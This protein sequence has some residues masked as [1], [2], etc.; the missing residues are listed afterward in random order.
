[1][2][3][4]TPG[5][6]RPLLF[7]AA[8][9]VGLV[10]LAAG[11]SQFQL[12]PGQPFPYQLIFSDSTPEAPQISTPSRLPATWLEFFTNLGLF[13]LTLVLLLWVITFIFKPNARKRMLQR[14]AYYLIL[15]LVLHTVLGLVRELQPL[16]DLGEGGVGAES[17]EPFEADVPL[18]EPPAFIVDPPQWLVVALTFGLV[19]LLFMALWYLFRQAK[20]AGS[21]PTE[22]TPIALLVQEA[23]QAL[24]HLQQGGDF[25][26]SVL[27]CYQAMT[28][29]LE[30]DRG[31]H[32]E[33][34]MT[35]RDFEAHLLGLG[36]KDAHIQRLTRLFEKVR[37]GASTPS[38]A[39]EEEAVD[40][41]SAIVQ[42]YGRAA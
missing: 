39:E 34:A 33:R 11:F 32:R 5:K 18:P 24:D 38:L 40:C 29:L 12:K 25:K 26:N 9:I 10:V 7:L 35:P 2:T 1:M 13:F 19:S 22:Q 17:G 20:P 21:S 30:E 27:A 36:L 3:T 28:R 8:I 14:I 15:L 31:I 6:I 41:L 23:Q 4:M 42:T 16:A 37:Y